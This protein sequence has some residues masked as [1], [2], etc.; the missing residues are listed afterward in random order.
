MSIESNREKPLNRRLT[1][2]AFADV[3]GFSTMMQR[4]EVETLFRWKALRREI[5]D[6][7]ISAARGR[8]R[9][10]VG[11]GLF[12]EFQSVVD[13]V[14]WAIAVQEDIARAEKVMGSEMLR[15]RIG[16]NVEDAIIEDD[17]LHGDGVNIASRIHQLAQPG[18]TIITSA[19]REYVR[20]KINV[21]ITDMGERPLKG[22][23]YPVRIY[24]VESG[25]GQSVRR[26]HTVPG[27]QG[28]Q[29]P[30]VAVLPFRNIGGNRAEDYFGEGITEEIISTLSR[31]RSLIVIARN[32]TLRYR[33]ARDD[34]HQIAEELGVRYVLE[35]T[36]RRQ[37]NRLRIAPKLLDVTH[38]VTLW[39]E[40]FE[41]TNDDLFEF[42]DQITTSIA[43][44]IEPRLYEA[45]SAR[46][47]TK[48]TE[49]L[50]A[51]DCVLHALPL[52]HRFN[53]RELADAAQFLDRA[54]KL[55]SSY[56]QAYAYRA[57]VSVLQVAEARTDEVEVERALARAH[58]ERAM[59]I[60]AHDPFV[61]AIS[62]HV[63]ALLHQDPETAAGLFQTSL[64]INPNSSFAWG[65]SGLTYCYLGQPD[66]A[67]ERFGRAWRLSPFD[68]LIF[69]YTA[70]A[71]LAE[72]LAERYENSVP[73]CNKALQ[74][75]PRFLACMRHKVATLAHL[76]RIDEARSV[77]K[78][79]IGLEPDFRVSR[80]E[81]WYPL[82][83]RANLDRYLWGLRAAGLPE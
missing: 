38:D 46:V 3:A 16:I 25:L 36:V 35:G 48:P 28:I 18:E 75:N 39:A 42:Q 83:P 72:F 26:P 58:V 33:E 78:N 61:L 19:V 1:A 12:V 74:V 13:A 10:V 71:G 9:R 64:D 22:L 40:R 37:A 44:R 65:M 14:S 57:W 59:T 79:I 6:P 24:C 66:E 4:D 70:G 2:I 82:Q 63:Y 20:N 21:R 7:A 41:G 49:R 81:G 8:L 52:L 53:R 73:W 32:S 27:E 76:G 68:P 47:R 29:R 31:S 60:D 23:A 45:E 77:G 5:I 54:I 55:D 50:D 30:S 80:L 51:Y 43:A 69:F 17:D 15:L 62:G 56:A 67:L 34:H 11:D